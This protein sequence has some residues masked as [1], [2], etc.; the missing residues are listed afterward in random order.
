VFDDEPISPDHPF[1]ELDNVVM[2]PHVAY[3]TPE[4]L[5]DMYD[6]AIDN[7]VAFYAGKPQNVATVP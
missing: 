6:T 2:T 7:L 5:A 4:A 1:L 3:N